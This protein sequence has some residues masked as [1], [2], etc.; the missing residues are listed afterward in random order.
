M[1]DAL[2]YTGEARIPRLLG[3]KNYLNNYF[4]MLTCLPRIRIGVK[5]ASLDYLGLLIN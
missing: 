3:V 4:A 1:S 5:L 2:P